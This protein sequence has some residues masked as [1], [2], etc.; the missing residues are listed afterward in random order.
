MSHQQPD[1]FDGDIERTNLFGDVYFVD[2]YRP[3][4]WGM[5]A[6]SLLLLPPAGAFALGY[7]VVS[8]LS[9]E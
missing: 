1:A 5:A 8:C 4:W 7:M 9:T 3:A 6:L 2:E